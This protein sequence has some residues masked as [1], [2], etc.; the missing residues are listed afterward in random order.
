MRQSRKP[1]PAP[2]RR[3][4]RRASATTAAGIAA[5]RIALA[6]RER[7]MS[8]ALAAARHIEAR[9]ASH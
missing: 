2:E 1:Q 8:H 5:E 6:E 9:P 3:R 7:R 4:R